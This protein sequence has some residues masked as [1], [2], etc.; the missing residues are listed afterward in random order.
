VRKIIITPED[1]FKIRAASVAAGFDHTITYPIDSARL[2]SV[3]QSAQQHDENSHPVTLLMVDDLLT[4]G[5]YWR[6]HFRNQNI[7]FLFESDPEKAFEVALSEGPDVILLD[8]YM[9]EIDG[10]DF[11]RILREHPRLSEVP[12]LFLSTEDHDRP[13]LEAKLQGGD[14]FLSKQ[15]APEDLV[16]VVHYRAQRFR[17]AMAARETDSL[18]GLLNHRA[19]KNMVDAEIDRASR[20]NQPFSVA[21]IDIDNFKHINDT[22]GHPT[23]DR[24]IRKLSSLLSTRLRRYDGI[25]RYGGE[26]FLLALPATDMATAERL[27]N[28]LRVSFARAEIYADNGDKL[29]CHFSAGIACFPDHITPAEIIAAADKALYQAKKQGRNRVCRDQDTSPSAERDLLTG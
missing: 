22:Y 18:T 3:L 12:I 10:V 23:G 16:R 27:V 11:A 17:R 21:M 4:T 29:T 8:L 25:G 7:R 19:I 13:Q 2:A 9:P 1:D 28:E 5:A 15:I 26:E 14:D 20:Q 6:K 24:V